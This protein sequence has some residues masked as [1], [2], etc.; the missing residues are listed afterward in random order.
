M[1]GSTAVETDKTATPSPWAE[2]EAVLVGQL[3]ARRTELEPL[4]VEYDDINEKLFGLD[5]T[6]VPARRRRHTSGGRRVARGEH[7][8]RFLGIIKESGPMTVAEVA[9]AYEAKGF[10]VQGP[11]LY[12]VADRLVK[13]GQ[14]FQTEDKKYVLDQEMPAVA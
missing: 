3:K 14:I 1:A 9:R 7:D 13:K 2:A 6:E 8:N 12:K 4:L 11:Y 10:P 5:P